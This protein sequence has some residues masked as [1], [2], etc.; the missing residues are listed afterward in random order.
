M[1]YM[2]KNKNKYCKNNTCEALAISNTIEDFHTTF[3]PI[4]QAIAQL[5]IILLIVTIRTFVQLK[6]HSYICTVRARKLWS[7]KTPI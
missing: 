1:F 4:P 3:V 2:I 5:K 7:V 6:L